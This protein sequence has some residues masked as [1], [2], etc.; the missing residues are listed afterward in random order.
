MGELFGFLADLSGVAAASTASIRV[1]LILRT[2][3]KEI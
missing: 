1:V 2:L 3:L